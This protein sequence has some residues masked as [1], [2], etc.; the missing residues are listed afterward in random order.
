[1][2]LGSV[3][4]VE[5]QAHVIVTDSSITLPTIH[6]ALADSYFRAEALNP[7]AVLNPEDQS[8]E[9]ATAIVYAISCL[10]Y[11]IPSPPSR[12]SKSKESQKLRIRSLRDGCRG[13]FKGSP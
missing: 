3:F 9:P 5:A 6:M 7:P 10:R 4:R 12:C 13:L 2:E 11:G 8:Y 1:M